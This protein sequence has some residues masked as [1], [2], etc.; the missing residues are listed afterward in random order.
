VEVRYGTTVRQVA[1]DCG[2]FAA[3]AARHFLVS[4]NPLP[5]TNNPWKLDRCPRI[6]YTGEIAAATMGKP[7]SPW[8][9]DVIA[10]YT[11]LLVK[12]VKSKDTS[13][14][15]T[16]ENSILDTGAFASGHKW[17]NRITS[18]RP[19]RGRTIRLSWHIG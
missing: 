12:P 9:H 2:I 8:K 13:S 17:S 11:G 16:F 3:W 5:I 10:T 6:A 15:V 4:P 14:G 7:V 19:F 1:H 18:L